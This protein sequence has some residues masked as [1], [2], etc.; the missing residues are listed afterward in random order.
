MATLKITKGLDI[1]VAGAPAG[2]LQELSAN[3][4]K[5][6]PKFVALDFEPFVDSKPRLLVKAGEVVKRGQPL[7]EDKGIEGVMFASPASGVVQEV[8][9]G[10]KR[11]LLDLVI[12][13]SEK[14]EIH[15]WGSLDVKTVSKEKLLERMKEGGVFPHIRQRPFDKLA[16]PGKTPRDIFVR[17]LD[18]APFA[19]PMEMQVKGHEED[20]QIGLDALAKLTSGKVHLVYEAGTSFKPFTDAKNV[21]THT[22]EG[23]HPAGLSSTHI[24]YIAPITHV[25]D[26][27][28]TLSARDVVVLGHLLR[29][30]E[31]LVDRVISI[32][33]P[34][35]IDGKTGYFRVR[36]GQQVEN[37]IAGRVSKGIMRF[38]S[39]DLLTGSK[40][41]SNG[42]L[43]FYHTQ[44]AVLPESVEREMLHFFRLGINKYTASHTYLSGFLDNKERSYEFNTSNHGEHRGFVIAKMYDKVMP[45]NIPTMQLMKALQGEDYDTAEKL[46]L[47]EVAPEDFALGTFV[48]PSKQELCEIVRKGLANYASEVLA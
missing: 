22:I 17:A 4:R 35:I 25:D 46:G 44:L 21:Q 10:L 16:D 43:G 19:P 1:P 8:R 41:E 30:G 34:G 42:F 9:R 24:H 38:V 32:A 45:M 15:N 36:A 48:C 39:G 28:W 33:G 20:F 3:G 12:E 11:R 29:T 26:T 27:V 18:T 2:E 5:L 47:L 37:L 31:Y 23:P 13:V 7:V 14:E 40:V 6:T